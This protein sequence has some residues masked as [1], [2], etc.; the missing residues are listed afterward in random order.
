[1]RKLFLLS[2]ILFI[3]SVIVIS[4]ASAYEYY[5]P[6]YDYGSNRD[7]YQKSTTHEE[8][9]SSTQYYPWGKETTTRYLKEQTSIK[10]EYNPRYY[11]PRSQ[12]YYYKPSKYSITY[13]NTPVYPTNFRFREP[14]CYSRNCNNYYEPVYDYNQGYFNWRY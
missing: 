11:Y 3:L 7:N 1:M 12:P 5:Y 8:K 13:V 2:A 4:Q 10:K 9:E 14:N 6:D